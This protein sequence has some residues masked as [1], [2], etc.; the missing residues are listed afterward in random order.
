MHMKTKKTTGL[1]IAIV[2]MSGKFPNAENIDQLWEK[3]IHGEELLDFATEETYKERN[4]DLSH[5]EDPDRIQAYSNVADA[6]FF[7]A[8]FFKYQKSEAKLMDPQIRVFHEMA[9]AALEDAGIVPEK[10]NAIGVYA[11]ANDNLLWK[12]H[13]SFFQKDPL[14]T[15]FMS[16]LL[17]DKDRLSTLVSYKLNLN[18]PSLFFRTGCSTSLVATHMACRALLTGECDTAIAGGITI[19]S[20][21]IPG[22]KYA[23]NMIFSSDGHTKTFDANSD[24]TVFY[25][26]RCSNCIEAFRKSKKR[27]RPYLCCYKRISYKQ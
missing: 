12:A 5:F 16:S 1:E 26:W 18:G 9:W 13:N 25:Q 7:D 17:C 22:Y 3:L 21:A 20:Q 8:P 27:Q 19:S 15:D 24:G 11:G 6:S 14:V 4:I 2:G 23:E 10:D